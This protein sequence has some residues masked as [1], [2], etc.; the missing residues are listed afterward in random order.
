MEQ[1]ME[2]RSRQQSS[3]PTNRAFVLQFRTDAD[4]EQGRFDGRIEHVVSGQT[5]LFHSLEELMQFL[6]QV[7]S[8]ASRQQ[9]DT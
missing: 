9:Q 4:I 2:L 5:T 6:S 1:P 7:L 3:L 8:L